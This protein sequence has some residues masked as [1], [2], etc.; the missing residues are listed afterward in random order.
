MSD[1]E[2]ADRPPLRVRLSYGIGSVAY[3]VKD[4]G[5]NFFLILFYGTVI[6]LE[7]ALVGLA[8]MIALIVDAFSDPIVGYWS[9][10]LRSKWGRRHPFMY[11]AALPCA[12]GFLLLW[13]PP[14]LPDT[15]LFFYVLVLAIIIRTAITFYET[16]SSALLPELTS[17]YEHRTSLQAW[18]LYFGWTGG[19][20]LTVIMFAFLLVPTA[21]YE[22]GLY[23]RDGY[24]LFGM[25]GA[26]LILV[27]I[28]V[29]AIGTQ[30]H[31]RYK[32]IDPPKA[33]PK[34]SLGLLF[35]DVFDTIKD[36]SFFAL[37][38]ATLFGAIASGVTAGLF[39]ILMTSFWG[40]SMGQLVLYS[41]VTFLGALIGLVIATPMVRAL[42]KKRAVILLGIG[43]FS[44]APLPIILRLFDLMPQNGDPLLF[45]IVAGVHAIDISLIIALQAV[46][47]SMAA[48]L[49]EAAEIRTGKRSEGVFYSAMTFTRKSSQGIGALIGGIILTL[50]SFPKAD[51]EA[52]VPSSTLWQLGAS[53]APT[54]LFLWTCMLVAISFYGIDK[55][56]HEATLEQLAETRD[57]AAIPK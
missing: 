47:Y 45:P 14:D 7:P 9:D 46:S 18:R 21:E 13:I 17:D 11:A 30:K 4:S 5:F 28:L 48:E 40:F 38:A 8:I 6:G 52:T 19:N 32:H 10:N 2:G 35:R 15:S 29:C 53:Y 44:M 33:G 25:I 36:K 31:V 49:V 23:N 20:I 22:V 43:G 24:A 41:L 1:I 50:V 12:V 26:A 57:A 56:R 16:P 39:V 27:S 55:K 51:P 3:G 42:G 54:V 37:F 34:F